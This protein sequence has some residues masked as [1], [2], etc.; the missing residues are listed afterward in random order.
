MT[1][2][3]HALVITTNGVV[4]A[5]GEWLQLLK[6]QSRLMRVFHRPYAYWSIVPITPEQLEQ[7][8]TKPAGTLYT[9]NGDK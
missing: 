2:A 8:Y 4:E 3:T 7:Y 9:I 5:V 6:H 1:K